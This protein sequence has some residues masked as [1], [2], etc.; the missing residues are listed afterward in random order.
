MKRSAFVG[1]LFSLGLPCLA[2]GG[3]YQATNRVLSFPLIVDDAE[4]E[5][6]LTLANPADEDAHLTVSA[7][8]EDGRAFA[9]LEAD[10]ESQGAVSATASELFGLPMQVLK[11]GWIQVE[12][13]GGAV[14]GFF[15]FDDGR[16]LRALEQTQRVFRFPLRFP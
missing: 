3:E 1:F 13:E 15:S 9:V 11:S 12:T 16:V 6:R 10:I 5:P 4:V 8:S 2:A 7:F 14:E